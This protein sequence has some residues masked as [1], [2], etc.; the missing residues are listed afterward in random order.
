MNKKTKNL[1]LKCLILAIFFNLFSIT[2]AFAINDGI[3]IVP[4]TTYYANPE[5][6]EIEDS[7]TDKA[8]GEAMCRSA[9]GESALLEV[10]D[11]KMYLTLRI[12]LISNISGVKIYTK[13]S[14]GSSY[15]Q[16]KT[17]ITAENYTNDYADY[18]FEIS[19]TSL[20][21]SIE[22]YVTP[23][24]RNVK[25]YA[26]IDKS[27]ATSG[28]GDFVTSIKIEETTQTI[29]TQPTTQ[30]IETTTNQTTTQKAEIATQTTTNTINTTQTT[31]QN[32]Q[33]VLED[34]TETTTKNT[35]N[36]TATTEDVQE[37]V[38]EAIALLE[39]TEDIENMENIED[40]VE[41]DIEEINTEISEDLE[42]NLEE[43]I[44]TVEQNKSNSLL[45][46]S[47]TVILIIVIIAIFVFIKKSKR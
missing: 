43:E 8:L 23:M 2:N 17:T 6:G 5:T 31:E 15:T 33:N 40:D 37:N 13:Q 29:T 42:E 22:F 27:S 47:T 39:E 38:T 16:A 3:Y 36:N 45:K 30:K 4:T 32:S 1:F 20:Y 9:L 18:R 10:K 21:M 26:S 11:G 44:E 24:G 12:K 34:I 19:D 28:N 41:E 7:G 14:S 35:Q 46:I 25:F